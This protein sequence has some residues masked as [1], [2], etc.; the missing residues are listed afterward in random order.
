MRPCFLILIA[1]YQLYTIMG[2]TVTFSYMHTVYF[3][4]IYSCLLVSLLLP[5]IPFSQ[6]APQFYF[7]SFFFVMTQGL[8]AGT[9]PPYQ[10]CTVEENISPLDIDNA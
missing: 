1:I 2:F 9:W 4:P 5:L 7:L 10:C 6:L 3:N 8:L